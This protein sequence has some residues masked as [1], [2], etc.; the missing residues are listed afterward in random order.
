MSKKTNIIIF[1]IAIILAAAAVYFIMGH[2]NEIKSAYTNIPMKTVVVAAQNI[3]EHVNIT[4]EVLKTLEVPEEMVLPQAFDS[5]GD[6][7]GSITKTD[8]AKD[9]HIL[10]NHIY[11]EGEGKDKFS[12]S[13]PENMR[14]ISLAINDVTGVS[15][16]IKANDRVDI[17]FTYAYMDRDMEEEPQPDT[18]EGET[19]V[20]EPVVP[21]N[22]SRDQIFREN[23][24]KISDEILKDRR[25][26]SIDAEEMTL[27]MLQNIQVLAVYGSSRPDPEGEETKDSGTITL[28]LTP[29]DVELLTNAE[30]IGSL[31]LSLRSP[32]DEG[33]VKL[34]PIVD[35]R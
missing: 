3:P 13:V 4:D 23:L 8:M 18:P 27:T 31:R 34:E 29:Q 12:Y 30:A 15:G 6:V 25:I 22:P 1:A 33:I 19:P 9:E 28:A 21:E 24:A 14:A 20:D 16:L 2:I 26:I 11:K 35:M 32:I 17:L 10:S 5:P 7:I